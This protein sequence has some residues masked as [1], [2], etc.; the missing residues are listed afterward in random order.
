M[1]HGTWDEVAVH[2]DVLSSISSRD[3]VMWMSKTETRLWTLPSV[4]MTFIFVKEGW[5]RTYLTDAL[6]YVNDCYV[7]SL[8]NNRYVSELEVLTD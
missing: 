7:E 8:M 1:N 4:K 2:G 5:F 3:S 6:G